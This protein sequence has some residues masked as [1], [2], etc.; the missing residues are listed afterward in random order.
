MTLFSDDGTTHF[1]AAAR[2]VFDVCGAG[3]TV[4]AV[5]AATLASGL[6][7]KKAVATANRAAGAVVGRFGVSVVRPEDLN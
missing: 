5:L 7:I 3:D 4:I 2:E 6:P 1:P